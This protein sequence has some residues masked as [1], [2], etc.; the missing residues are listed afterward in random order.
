[1]E[2]I[3]VVAA[4]MIGAVLSILLKKHSPEFSLLIGIVTGVLIF[5]MIADSLKD[6]LALLKEMADTAGINMAYLSIV[7]K[8]IGIAY[9]AEFGIQLCADAGEKSIASKI[10]LAGKVLI[11]VISAPVL[12]ALMNM[13][14]HM[15][16]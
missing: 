5:M 13:V 14:L 3:Q 2:I 6:V 8:V 4:G 9:I 16:A 7:M 11:M 1:M 10:E 15:V 12:L